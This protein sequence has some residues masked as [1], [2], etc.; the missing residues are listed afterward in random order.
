MKVI[1][2]LKATNPEAQDELMVQVNQ[3][4]FERIMGLE[5]KEHK[6]NISRMAGKTLKLPDIFKQLTWLK[7]HKERL[8]AVRT[9]MM[10]MAE[11][12]RDLLPEED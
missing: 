1:A 6:T 11:T 5:A 2:Y 4:E 8:R 9:T 3:Q 10:D 7:K 12:F